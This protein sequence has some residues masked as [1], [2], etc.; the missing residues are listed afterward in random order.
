MKYLYLSKQELTEIHTVKNTSR[1]QKKNME[2]IHTSQ[3][4]ARFEG[5]IVYTICVSVGAAI[6]FNSNTISDVIILLDKCMALA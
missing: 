3:L 6:C 5:T 2:Y 4:W 1:S